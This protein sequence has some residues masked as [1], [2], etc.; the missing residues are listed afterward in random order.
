MHQENLPE[1]ERRSSKR[2]VK[3]RRSLRLF[4]LRLLRLKGHPKE[5]AGGMAIGVFIGMTPTVPLHTILAVSIAFLLKKSKLAAAAGVWISNPLLL[6]W[7]YILD[8]KIGRFILG[9][10]VRPFTFSNFSI[11]HLIRLGWQISYPLFIG[12]FITGLLLA[13][14]AYFI[15][16]QL[17]LLYREK[18]RKRSSKVEFSSKKT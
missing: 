16:K 6:P 7:I 11:S 9:E 15:T 8:Y 5:V 14:P 18:R 10:A 4:Y 3:W 17:I 2:R 12:G 13:I 1:K